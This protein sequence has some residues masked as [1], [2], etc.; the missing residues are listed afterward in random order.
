MRQIGG[1]GLGGLL[2]RAEAVAGAVAHEAL[3]VI[4]PARVHFRNDIDEDQP[5]ERRLARLA[6]REKRCDA[7]ERRPD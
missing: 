1:N 5:C 3:N 7:A 2:D 6:E 4:H